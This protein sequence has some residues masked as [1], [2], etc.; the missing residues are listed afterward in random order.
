M[1]V[2]VLNSLDFGRKRKVIGVLV[3]PRSSDPGSLV[4][5]DEGMIWVNTTSHKAKFYNGTAATILISDGA[6]FANGNIPLAKLATDPLARA[7]HTGTQTASTISDFDTQVRTSRL[8]QMAAPNV[9]LS[10]ASHKITNVTDPTSAQDAATKAYVD[11][12]VL[13]LSFKDSVRAASTANGT[14]STAFE[15]GDSLDGVTL[16]TGDRVLLKNQTTAS[17]NGIYTVNASGAPTRATDFD[18]NTEP[19]GAAV[20][21]EEGSTQ[22]GT[23]WTLTTDAPITIGSTSLAF[24][25][26]SGGST[27]IAGA[28]LTLTT[29]TF[30]V[31][32]GTGISVAADSVAIDTTVVPRFFLGTITGDNTTTSFTITHSLNNDYPVVQVWDDTA[33]PKEQVMVKVERSSINAVNVIFDVAPSSTGPQVYKV[34][35]M[36]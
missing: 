32:A 16:A 3:D 1:T 34:K 36:A 9:D 27:Y 7:N 24:A 2:Q 28:G 33:S 35:V 12:A 31:G 10:M 29:L 17:E 13:G 4:S 20:Y 8:D 30:D 5:G 11:N 19:L 6:D 22:A 23:L 15:N 25:Q 26:F 21:V 18:S 14:L